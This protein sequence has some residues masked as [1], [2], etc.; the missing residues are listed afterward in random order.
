M[1]TEV[2]ASRS[3]QAELIGKSTGSAAFVYG[4]M[5]FLDKFSNG[6][7][8]YLIQLH[9]HALIEE[10]GRAGSAPFVRQA[11]TLGCGASAAA[12]AL[13]AWLL[14]LSIASRARG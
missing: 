9:R 6:V 4:A 5:S 10:G 7:A 8:I 3:L 12:G 14:R 1:S 11:F 13:F 2:N